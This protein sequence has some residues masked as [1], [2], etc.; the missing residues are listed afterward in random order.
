MTNF[1]FHNT[2]FQLIFDQQSENDLLLFRS[3][4]SYIY[5]LSF[6]AFAKTGKMTVSSFSFFF[7]F[8]SAANPFVCANPLTACHREE[9]QTKQKAYVQL[10]PVSGLEVHPDER[11]DLKNI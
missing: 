2:I 8:I 4:R 10:Q 1:Y 5:W 3:R 7:N 6:R 11:I 9:T